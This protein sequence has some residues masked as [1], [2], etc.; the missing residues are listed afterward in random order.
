MNNTRLK[1]DLTLLLAAAIWGSGFVAQKI[2]S[3]EISSFVFNGLRFTAGG[4][5]LALG[6]RFNFP[7]RL[8]DWRWVLLG[9][10]LLFGGSTLQQIGIA[11]TTAANAGF[12]TG[13]YVVIIPI[14]LFIFGRQRPGWYVWAAAGMAVTGTLL[15]SS[16]SLRIQLN[17]G[18][19]IVLGG[20]LVW[21]LHVI[22][23]GKAANRMNSLQFAAG[24]A[25]IC[26]LLNLAI[27]W[28]WPQENR[29]I[30]S[31]TTLLAIAYSAVFIVSLAFT[32]QVMGQRY[33]PPTD[34]AILFSSEAVF[35]ALFG[36]LLL[37]ERLQPVQWLGAALIFAAML[38]SQGHVLLSSDL[39]V[40]P[41]PMSRPADT[42]SD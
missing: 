35:A 6:L 5:L 37:G 38:L 4:I 10:I 26:G 42:S 3:A 33:A 20:A 21:A 13:L 32:L 41:A 1:S 40:S 18:D 17:T 2:A 19:T 22:V 30:M 28:G 8:K 16:G 25:L 12:I 11:T 39:S 34:A 27:V 7:T 24:Q 14:L 36:A 31:P 23:V 29:L 9:G 15:L